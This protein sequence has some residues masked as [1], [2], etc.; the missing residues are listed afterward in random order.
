[1]QQNMIAVT[2]AYKTQKI[3]LA[4]PMGTA[5]IDALKNQALYQEYSAQVAVPR[6]GIFSKEV[7]STYVLQANDRIE[8]YEPLLHDPMLQRKSK[9]DPNRY[10]RKP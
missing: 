7:K 5:V 4:V 6:V 3:S 10:R 2:L 9:V 1:M 8:L